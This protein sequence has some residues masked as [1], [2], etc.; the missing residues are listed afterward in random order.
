[1]PTDPKDPHASYTGLDPAR[2]AVAL[3]RY[4]VIADLAQ[5][6][7]QHRGLYKL[8]HAKAEREYDIPGSLRR[9]VAAETASTRCYHASEQTTAARARSRLRWST[10]CAC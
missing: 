3:F 10:C 9:R 2:Q 6:P 8:L 4:S 1:M 5:L 7:A